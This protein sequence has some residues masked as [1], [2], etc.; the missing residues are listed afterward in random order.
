MDSFPWLPA[1]TVS[2]GSAIILIVGGVLTDTGPWYRS[3]TKPDWQPP[4][5]LFAPA[6]TLIY[7]LTTWGTVLAWIR[8]GGTIELSM[9]I[10]AFVLNG[11]LN[12]GWS[13]MF[14]KWRRP[15]QALLEIVPLWISTV[16]LAFIAYSLDPLAGWLLAPYALW[17]AFAAYLNWAVVRLN[18]SNVLPAGSKAV[19]AP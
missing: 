1:L 9:L 14:F 10:T 12:I 16:L 19:A 18:S 4:G 11:M 17:V 8:A 6:W 7:V 13:L 15:D 2:A 5:W 3:L